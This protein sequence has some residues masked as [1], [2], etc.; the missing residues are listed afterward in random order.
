MAV[1]VSAK[2]L[3]A[4]TIGNVGLYFICYK[5]SRAGWNAMPTARNAKGVD[6]LVYSQDAKRTHAIQVKTLSQRAPVPLGTH[7]N[8]L[9]GDWFVICRNVATESPECFVLTPG[10]VR[11]LAHRGEKEGRVSF[12]LQPK[13]YEGALFHE[14]WHRI[15]NGFAC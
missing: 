5:P 4:Q 8:N 11:E 14:A 10:E 9:F 12:W 13:Q 3:N 1:S 15:G 7:L 2:Q 6:I